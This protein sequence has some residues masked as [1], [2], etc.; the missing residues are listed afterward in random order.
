V[1][2]YIL[3]IVAITISTG[4][5]TA[6]SRS[7]TGKE[8]ASELSAGEEVSVEVVAPTVIDLPNSR[9]AETMILSV[10]AQVRNHGKQPVR[11]FASTPCTIFRW[12]VWT[13][14]DEPVQARP[15]GKCVQAIAT[16]TLSGAQQL[17]RSYEL[18]LDPGL[19]V[20]GG[21]YVLLYKF[22]GYLGRHEFT[23]SQ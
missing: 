14:K 4:C 22:W 15:G 7:S 18:T 16:A 3:F 1:S 5:A 8:V 23:V 2:R 9:S 6:T 19:Y 10:T 11:L 12:S 17:Q 20:A 21:R 13:E